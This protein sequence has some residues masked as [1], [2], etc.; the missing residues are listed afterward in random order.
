M[1]DL[2]CHNKA[3]PDA[4]SPRDIECDGLFKLDTDD[5]IWQDVGLNDDYDGNVPPQWLSDEQVRQG[6]QALLENDRCK[7]EEMRLMRE[8]YA[9]QDWMRE[10]WAINEKT[11][12][13]AG[14]LHL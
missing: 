7:E 4:I 6:I 10:E 1:R 8:R 13:I 9:M 11:Q 12:Q 5:D 3:P 14:M 2:I